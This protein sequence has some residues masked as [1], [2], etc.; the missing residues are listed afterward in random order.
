MHHHSLWQVE[1]LQ[2]L[3][4]VLPLLLGEAADVLLPPEVLGNDGS[5]EVEG[6]HSVDW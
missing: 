4:E 2:L 3:R 1:L 6:L 5:Q